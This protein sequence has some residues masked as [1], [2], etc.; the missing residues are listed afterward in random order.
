MTGSEAMPSVED[1]LS[2]VCEINQKYCTSWGNF[3]HLFSVH[4]RPTGGSTGQ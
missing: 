1:I 4:V 2:L 3:T